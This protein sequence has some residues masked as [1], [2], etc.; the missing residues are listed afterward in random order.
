MPRK[1]T[2]SAAM[3]TKGARQPRWL[4]SHRESGTPAIVEAVLNTPI[5]RGGAGQGVTS[6]AGLIAWHDDGTQRLLNGQEAGGDVDPDAIRAAVTA[7][8]EAALADLTITIT[9][10]G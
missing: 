3:N 9:P 8:V 10:K 7:S 6:L 1:T 4:A 5:P 2:L